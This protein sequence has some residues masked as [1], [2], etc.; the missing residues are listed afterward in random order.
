M[1]HLQIHPGSHF[2][3]Q[4]VCVFHNILTTHINFHLTLLPGLCCRM[5][6]ESLLC[7]VGIE[8]LYTIHKKRQSSTLGAYCSSI[9]P[10][11][12]PFNTLQ[13]SNFPPVSFSRKTKDKGWE[14]SAQRNLLPNNP[15]PRVTSVINVVSH[16]TRP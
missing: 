3:T 2:S 15:P 8:Y 13:P 6:K 11:T 14:T 7:F 9:L 4:C 1:H 16:N 5:D 10:I 12:S